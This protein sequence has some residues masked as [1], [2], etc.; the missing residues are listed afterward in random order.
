MPERLRC[1]AGRGGVGTMNRCSTL[2]ASVRGVVGRA[3]PLCERKFVMATTKP[4]RSTATDSTNVV[5]A[6]VNC[7]M[8][9]EP[10]ECGWLA[11][12]EPLPMTRLVWQKIRPRWVRFRMPHGSVRVIQPR[13]LGRGCPPAFIC[14]SCRFTCFSYDEKDA[15]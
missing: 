5:R 12:Y 13:A 2:V 11:V 6:S 15:T 1:S 8:C 3:N 10:M 4:S 9:H 14:R 7:P